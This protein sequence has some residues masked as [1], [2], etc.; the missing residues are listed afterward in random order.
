MVDYVILVHKTCMSIYT[1]IYLVFK[2]V[3]KDIDL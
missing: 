2:I 3:D 1:H